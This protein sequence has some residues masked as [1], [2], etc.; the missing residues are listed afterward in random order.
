MELESE[1]KPMEY[2]IIVG[3]IN[4][5]HHWKLAVMYPQQRKSLFLDPLGESKQDIKTC[6]ETTRAFMRNKG[7]NVSRWTCD[8][9]PHPKQSDGTSCGVFAL[10]FAEELLK[11]ETVDFPATKEAII[12]HR[13]QIAV[14][15]LLETDDLTDI[16]HFCGSEGPKEDLSW[17][18]V[19]MDGGGLILLSWRHRK[20]RR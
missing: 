15:L 4:E 6:L 14:T 3:I 11:N 7:C 12:T 20:W 10:K 19:K 5:H 2:K 9:V 17:N 1:I 16:C 18:V 13:L 8:T